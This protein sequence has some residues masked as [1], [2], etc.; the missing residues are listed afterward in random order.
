MKIEHKK[1]FHDLSKTLKNISWPIN[2]CIKYFMASTK[3]DQITEDLSARDS[4]EPNVRFF[5]GKR[6]RKP[7]RTK[8]RHRVQNSEHIISL[9]KSIDTIDLRCLA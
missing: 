2:I 7:Q 8:L 6:R 9:G 5:C 4:N 3:G 1:I